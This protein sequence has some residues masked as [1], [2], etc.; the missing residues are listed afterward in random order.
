M[1]ILVATFLGASAASVT[2]APIQPSTGYTW[3]WPAASGICDTPTLQACIDAVDT[4]DTIVIET[5]A[6]IDESLTISRSLDL[7]GGEGF[8][9]V[10]NQG[11]TVAVDS[12]GPNDRVIGIH[13]LKIKGE[14][15][16]N[17][18]VGVNHAITVDHV[19]SPKGISINATVPATYAIS[20]NHLH[21]FYFDTEPGSGGNE[22]LDFI[23]N[24][25]TSPNAAGEVEIGVGGAMTAIANVYDNV[26]WDLS[27]GSGID[28][29]TSGSGS[30]RVNAAGNT[31]DDVSG[32]GIILENDGSGS[33]AAE[34][35]DNV[36]AHTVRA[37]QISSATDFSHETVDLG[38][39]DSF[40]NSHASALGLFSA[41]T[42][43][44]TADPR[45]VDAAHGDLSLKANSTLIDR[46]LTCSTAGLV[47]LDAAGNGRFAGLSVDIG[48][49]EVPTVAVT[50]QPHLTG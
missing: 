4:G 49:Y 41:G 28:V 26:I 7:Y 43:N 30:L 22:R 11:V 9:P 37:I 48:A 6:A 38:Y 13:E 44:R 23:A 50:S 2:A 14:I 33:V 25:V 36:F 20:Q 46:G 40:G 1:A 3:G 32:A 42:G 47:D 16:V 12:A 34:V 8:H 35:F 15:T 10:I 29:V 17:V 31:V 19:T 24:H 27:E 21:Y 5:N 18:S 45:F 39:N